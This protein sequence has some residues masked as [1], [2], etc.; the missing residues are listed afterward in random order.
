AWA[1]AFALGALLA[2]RTALAQP[3]LDLSVF[4]GR[5]AGDGGAATDA[6]LRSPRNL[7]VDAAGNILVADAG[8]ARVR[9][10]DGATGV[11]TT[12]AGNGAPGQPVDGDQAVLA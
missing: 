10:I 6:V 1:G 4:A 9:R 7:A 5:G 2:N 3:C 12:V 8:N 11:I